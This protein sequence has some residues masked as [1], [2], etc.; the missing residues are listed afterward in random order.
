MR[1]V[2]VAAI[3]GL[4]ANGEIYAQRVTQ[5]QME[6]VS[7]D[8]SAGFVPKAST[9]QSLYATGIA[10]SLSSSSYLYRIDNYDS[11][12][13]ML[14]VGD[15]QQR[16]MD[17]AIDPT[18]GVFYGIDDDGYLSEINQ[19]NG[20]ASRIGYTGQFD[21]N[22]LE[23][24]ATGQAWAWGGFT[25]NLYRVD[26]ESGLATR[27]GSTGFASGGDLAFDA[28]GTLYGTT[29]NQLIRINKNTGTGT[30]VG[31]LG[32][33]GAY[34]LE[35]DSD[36]SMYVGRGDD[37][38]PLAQ[39][40]RVNKNN[41]STTFLGS[42]SGASQYGLGGL[43]FASLS[44][45]PTIFLQNG[46]FKVEATWQLQ[47][48]SKGPGQPVLLTSDTGYFWFFNASNVEF[49]IKVLDACGINNRFWVFAGG[50]TNV[51][52]DIRVTDT[53]TGGFKNYS[54][55]QGK[56]FQPVQDTNAFATC[57]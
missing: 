40:Y 53:A 19:G 10:R 55:P 32:F 21:L 13:S 1:L 23:F 52:V 3:M 31:P 30:L 26:K 51:R 25:G 56:P 22:A 6:A 35:I 48:G 38:S 24:D 4:L 45:N 49:V 15:T 16:L 43:A 29:E 12:P 54:N 2:I 41:A 27:V 28:N 17:L 9:G 44:S 8:L 18:T 37:F 5:V 50:L 7:E 33:S 46:R 20:F 42:I 47:N 34:G 11:S 36:G 39:V 14:L 57:P